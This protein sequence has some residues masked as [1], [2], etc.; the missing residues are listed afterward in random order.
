MPVGRLVRTGL[1]G[2]VVVIYIALVGLLAKT[3]EINLIGT[4][5]TGARVV[6]LFVPFLAAYI[7]VRPRVVAGE[8]VTLTTRSAATYGE[9]AGLAAGCSVAIALVFTN[10]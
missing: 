9:I 1:V 5:V 2:G 6:L 4:Q 7:V 3:A 10:W 8:I